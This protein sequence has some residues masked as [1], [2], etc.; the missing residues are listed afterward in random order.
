[1]LLPVLVEEGMQH[2][3]AHILQLP[4]QLYTLPKC[5]L[6]DETRSARVACSARSKLDQAEQQHHK[7]Q[8][9]VTTLKSLES[10]LKKIAIGPKIESV[11]LHKTK[12]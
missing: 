6:L 7:P 1:M 4:S 11:G 3:K 2:V 5:S 12:L 8:A 9:Q 10:A